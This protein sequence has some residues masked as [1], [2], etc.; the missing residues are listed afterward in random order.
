MTMLYKLG[1][2]FEWHGVGYDTIVVDDDGLE[3]A[4]NNG[5][6]MTA[7]ECIDG[8]LDKGDADLDGEVT[9]KEMETK[10][11]ELGIP[12]NHKTTNEKLLA[13]INEALNVVD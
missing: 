3:D 4:I 10:A 1:T 11:R 8:S 5:W 13:K 6:F 12:F 7:Q 2:K 9:R